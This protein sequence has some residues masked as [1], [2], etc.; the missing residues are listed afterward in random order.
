MAKEKQK[1]SRG[2]TS[3]PSLKRATLARALRIRRLRA[4]FVSVRSNAC[5]QVVSGAAKAVVT[6]RATGRPLFSRRGGGMANALPLKVCTTRS[7]QRITKR[8]GEGRARPGQT[9]TAN[10][11]PPEPPVASPR[12]GRFLFQDTPARR[13]FF[14]LS[15]LF[16]FCPAGPPARSRRCCRWPPRCDTPPSFPRSAWATWK[17]AW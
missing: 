10:E 12:E 5:A 4:P 13:F 9:A 8:E 7:G 6:D 1:G 3:G 15:P 11:K 14:K 17:P 16:I 2:E